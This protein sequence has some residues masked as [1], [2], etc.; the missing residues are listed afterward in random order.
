[1]NQKIKQDEIIQLGNNIRDIRLEKKIKQEEMVAKLQVKG[2]SISRTGYTKIELGR[3]H[4]EASCL[5]AIKDILNTTYERIF[6]HT[7]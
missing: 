7:N 6:E 2:I 5:E 4:I 3:R 1:M